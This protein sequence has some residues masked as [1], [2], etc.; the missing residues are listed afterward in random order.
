MSTH[1]DATAGSLDLTHWDVELRNHGR[2]V[3]KQRQTVLR[4][5]HGSAHQSAESI[6]HSSQEALPELT[7]QSVYAILADLTEI[8]LLR[9]ISPDVG[10][11][12]YETHTGDNHHHAL[13]TSCGAIE[14]VD[15]AVGHAPCLTPSATGMRIFEAEV[16]YYG[17]C[18]QCQALGRTP[19]PRD[20]AS[21]LLGTSRPIQTFTPNPIEG[22]S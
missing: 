5:A 7:L 12:K 16:N 10:P 11:A 14:D 6:W 4:S 3:T 21:T 19:E 18:A 1:D 2:R 9:K 17:L 15:C 20:H 8:G 22:E 13:C